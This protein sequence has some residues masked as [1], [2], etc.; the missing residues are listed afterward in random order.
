MGITPLEGLIMGTRAGDADM[1]MPFYVMR[2]TGMNAA[3]MEAA[4]NKK[5]G[6]LGITGHYADRRDIQEAALKG[7][8]KAILAQDME[9]YRVK[10]YIGAYQA[11]LG[12]VDALVFTAGVGEFAW[13]MR[14]KILE[15]LE[16]MGIV[17]DP[18]KNEIAHTRNAETIISAENS[19]IPVYIIPT[20]EELVMTEDAYALM[21]GTYDV[22]TNFTYS[23]QH[24]DYVNKGRAAGLK[25]EL[26]KNPALGA[27]IAEPK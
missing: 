11:V 18:K 25:E 14:R 7:D 16:D 19:K 12:R 20:D 21:S 2:K 9:A 1:A 27:I 13:F 23:F 4:L 10:K 24:K 5:S 26:A 15:G 22:H 8:A 17:Y 3:E 6:L